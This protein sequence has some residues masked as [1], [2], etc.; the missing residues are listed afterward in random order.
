MTAT[1]APPHTPPPHTPPHSRAQWLA[2]AAVHTYTATGSVL[3]LLMVHYSYRGDVDT[4]LWLFFAAM[5]VDGTDGMLAR[6][7]RVKELVPGFDGAL[8]DNIVDYMTYVLAPMALLWANGYLP[9]GTFGGIVAAVPLMASCVQFCRTDAKPVVE[10][11]HFFLGFPSYWN[12]LAFY[13]IATGMGTTATAVAILVC[14]VLVF[15]PIRYVYPSRT[16]AL[17]QLTFVLTALWFVAY[18]V[19]VAQ[20]P[21]PQT[22]IVAG[23]VGYLVYYV[24]LSLWL[25]L[26]SGRRAV[27]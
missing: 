21:D 19:I 14:T 24:A 15:V 25:T 10:G 11:E 5:V 23:S 2:A 26:A 22:W 4:V 1:P 13:V 17:W 12:V 16:E 18:A 20:L 8:L 3:A 27:Q 6:R 7:F 9:D